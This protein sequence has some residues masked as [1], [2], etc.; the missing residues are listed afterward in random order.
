MPFKGIHLPLPDFWWMRSKQAFLCTLDVK[1]HGT[2]VPKST[3]GPRMSF[4]QNSMK[5]AWKIYC[6]SKSNMFVRT[7]HC[8]DIGLVFQ[9]CR[10][11]LQT[12]PSCLEWWA[13]FFL[14][15]VQIPKKYFYSVWLVQFLFLFILNIVWLVLK[16][17]NQCHNNQ[18]CTINVK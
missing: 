4:K 8:F 3:H 10:F 13:A 11:V 14:K 18:K 2:V 9:I 15:I 12:I 17:L 6:V 5:T 1:D 16:S 7:N